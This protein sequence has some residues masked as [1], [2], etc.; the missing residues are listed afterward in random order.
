VSETS[1]GI[2]PPVLKETEQ[3]LNAY[4][5][6]QLKKFNI[7]LAPKGTEFQQ[8]VWQKLQNIPYGKTI[9]YG[10][11]AAQM[12]DVKKMRAVG[13]A[14][15]KNPIPIIIPCHRVIGADGNLTGY[16]GGLEKKVILLKHEGANVLANQ[17]TFF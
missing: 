12:G 2:K 14:N 1:T 11:L 4:F 9:T 8:A 7:P 15:G 17:L 10:K 13:M 6:N 3:Q 5:K 16:A